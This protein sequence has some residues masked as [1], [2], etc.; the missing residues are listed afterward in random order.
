M[1][2]KLLILFYER[3][4]EVNVYKKIDLFFLFLQNHLTKNCHNLFSMMIEIHPLTNNPTAAWHELSQQQKVIK[5]NTKL[6]TT[7]APNDKVKHLD[8]L[9]SFFY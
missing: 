6:P 2:I 7:D 5:I 3:Y 9:L 8:Y 4:N 1:L